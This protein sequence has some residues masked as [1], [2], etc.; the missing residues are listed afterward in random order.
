MPLRAVAAG[1]HHRLAD[2]GVAA[3][4]RLHL[5]GL[6]PEAADL[7]LVVGP[8]EELQHPVGAPAG[9]VAGAVEPVAGAGRVGHEGPRG[10]RGVARVAAGQAVAAGVEL[11]GHPDRHRPQPVVEDLH[12]GVLD[13]PA[14]RHRRPTRPGSVIRWQVVKVVFS[15]GP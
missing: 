15:V 13:R 14:D 11:A 8:A 1:Q 7:D 12:A 3:Q 6:D 4:H 10:G 5:A 9:Q 2:A